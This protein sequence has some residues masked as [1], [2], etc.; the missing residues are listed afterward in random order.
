MELFETRSTKGQI[1]WLRDC[2]SPHTRKGWEF[3][4]LVWRQV[5]SGWMLSM[6]INPYRKGV[7]KRMMGLFSVVPSKE[8]RQQL[9]KGGAVRTSSNTHLLWQWL[10]IETGCG[11]CHLWWIYSNPPRHSARKLTVGDPLAQR[12]HQRTSKTPFQYQL[13]VIL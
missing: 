4:N 7:K 11:I 10:S 12:L 3:C 2:S 6:D 13:S 5:I 9:Q 1:W 8:N